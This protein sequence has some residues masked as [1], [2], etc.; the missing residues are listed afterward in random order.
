[1]GSHYIAQAGLKL[2]SSSNSPALASSRTWMNLETIILSKLK[3]EQKIKHRMFSL[4]ELPQGRTHCLRSGD[5]RQRDTRVASAT[6]LAGAMRSIRTD[7][8]GWSHPHK[9]NSN[10][11]R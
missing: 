4:I 3:Q 9:E 1:M 11:K 7:W 2:L 6:L 8:L 5:S 10:W